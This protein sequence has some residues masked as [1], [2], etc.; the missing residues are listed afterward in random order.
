MLFGVAKPRVEMF[1]FAL[2]VVLTPIV[3]AREVMRVIQAEHTNGA[4]GLAST[5]FPTLLAAVFA[6]LA[7]FLALKWLSRWLEG[8]R[9]YFFGVYCLIA[10]AI[11]GYLHR[12]GY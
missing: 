6:F 2:A 9:W 4:A 7:G 10:A 1:S 12:A 3:L 8:G 5:L 11:V